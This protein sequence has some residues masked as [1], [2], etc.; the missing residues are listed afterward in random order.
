MPFEFTAETT[1]P[2]IVG[3]V[4]VGLAVL[5]RGYKTFLQE[6]KTNPDIKFDGTYML[7]FWVST[8]IAGAIVTIIPPL[9]TTLLP[10]NAGPITLYSIIVNAVLGYTTA[11]TALDQMNTSTENKLIANKSETATKPS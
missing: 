2:I 3:L 5:Q 1:I 11:W 9:L 10:S 6:K 8:G 7:N 4:F